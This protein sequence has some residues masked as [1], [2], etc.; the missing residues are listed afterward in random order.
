MKKQKII[1]GITGA[2]GLLYAKLLLEKL[3]LLHDQIDKCG[4]IFSENAKPVWKFELN[5]DPDAIKYPDWITVY[6]PGNLFAPMASGSSGYDTMIICPCTMGT[7]G[8]IASGIST[9][10]LTRAADVM[11][12]ERRK[13]ILV[14]REAPFNLIHLNNMKLLTETGAIICPASPSFYSKPVTIEELAMTVVDR[15]LVLAGFEFPT[16]HWGK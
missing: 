16:F 9:D 1:I 8:R 3:S 12:K 5:S 10:L 4:I 13:L 6:D 2:S 11:L 15:V 7:L 14:P